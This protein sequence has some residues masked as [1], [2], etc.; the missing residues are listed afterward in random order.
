MAVLRCTKKLLTQVGLKQV[1]EIDSTIED[2]HANLIWIER[3]KAVLFCSDSTLF[4][5]LAPAVRK[6]QIQTLGDLFI[7]TLTQS[8]AYEGYSNDLISRYVSRF[9]A[10]EI[11]RTNNRSVLGSMNDYVFHLEYWMDRYG[12][13]VDAN[14]GAVEHQLNII[15]QVKREFF[16][17]LEAFDE[18]VQAIVQ[19]TI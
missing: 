6:A 16:N 4:C 9:E 17:S 12:G 3:K 11:T 2:W 19:T 1:P 14:V 15:P 8:M 18:R 10:I 13:V 5:C 7:S